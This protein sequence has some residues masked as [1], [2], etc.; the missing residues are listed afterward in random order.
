MEI[1]RSLWAIEKVFD[2]RG[3][4]TDERDSEAYTTIFIHNKINANFWKMIIYNSS[5]DIF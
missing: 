1:R 2:L 3:V 5:V 4:Q